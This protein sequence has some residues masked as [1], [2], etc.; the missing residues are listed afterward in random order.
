MDLSPLAELRL[1]DAED[2]VLLGKEAEAR[3]ERTVEW[4]FRERDINAFERYRILSTLHH[5]QHPEDHGVSPVL[6]GE[7]V[8]VS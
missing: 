6:S 8:T 5:E 3:V 7:G 4:D 1:R 2:A